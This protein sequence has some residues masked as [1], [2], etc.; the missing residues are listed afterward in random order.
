MAFHRSVQKVFVDA[1]TR[2]ASSQTYHASALNSGKPPTGSAV[3]TTD[4]TLVQSFEQRGKNPTIVI[5]ITISEVYTQYAKALMRSN[6]WSGNDD[7][8]LPTVG[9]I[10]ADMTNGAA[11][12]PNYDAG[13]T[14]YAKP[15]MW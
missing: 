1:H 3:L 9:E 4:P 12:E 15:R 2:V 5:V 13:Y 10:L 8:G 6:L 7:E 11:C 14:E